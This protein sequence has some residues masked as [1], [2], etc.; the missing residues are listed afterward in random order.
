MKAHSHIKKTVPDDPSNFFIH[1]ANL[2]LSENPENLKVI[3]ER[4]FQFEKKYMLEIEAIGK[5]PSS[6][7]EQVEWGIFDWD[8]QSARIQ[9]SGLY[10]VLGEIVNLIKDGERHALIHNSYTNSSV[11]TNSCKPRLIFQPY[12][13]NTAFEAVYSYL[14]N[15]CEECEYNSEQQRK[16]HFIDVYGKDL[17]NGENRVNCIECEQLAF[18]LMLNEITSNRR[19]ND[20]LG[21]GE[22]LSARNERMKACMTR[23]IR[24]PHSFIF[25]QDE[26]T[27]EKKDIFDPALK[28]HRDIHFAN[29]TKDYRYIFSD[30][31]RSLMGFSLIN[32]LTNKKKGD[33]YRCQYEDC[34]IFYLSKKKDKNNKFCPECS[35]KNKMTKE[36]QKKYFKKKYLERR[37]EK[38]RSKAQIEFMV[39]KMTKKRLMKAGNTKE[40]ANKYWQ[41]GKEDF[42]REY[43]SEQFFQ[44]GKKRKKSPDNL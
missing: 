42:L 13:H 23:G 37:K 22:Y 2:S 27:I 6:H 38:V 12:F 28:F 24:D 31:L 21:F 19:Y 11:R 39:E 33:I 35:P 30:Y 44:N 17:L 36:K 40:E 18:Q 16:W 15:G 1:Y 29:Y 4:I 10:E 20:L 3:F 14:D 9:P 25:S 41:I 5:Q 43:S 34:S 32:Y 8:V 7:D 26:T